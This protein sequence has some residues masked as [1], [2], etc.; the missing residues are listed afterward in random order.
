[1]KSASGRSI[2]CRG[3]FGTDSGHGEQWA[4]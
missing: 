1:L 2:C 4:S 3:L